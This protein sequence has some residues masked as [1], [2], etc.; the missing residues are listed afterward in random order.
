MVKNMTPDIP[1]YGAIEAGGTKFICATGSDPDHI[2]TEVRFSTTTPDETI[3]R[4][5]AFFC[6]QSTATPLTAIGVA[7]FGP[8]DLD[9][10][11]PAYGYITSTPKP[12][13]AQTNLLG[14]IRD[15]LNLPAGF[16]TDTNAA[17]L[18]EY[19]W[20]AGQGLDDFIYLT[21]GTGIGG[22]IIANGK[23]V[24]GLVH[25][26]M[27]HILLSH[28]FKRD[29]FEGFCP[30]H[31]DCFEGLATGPAL[32]ARWKCDPETLPADHPAWELEAHYIA[33]ALS[34][35]VCTLSPKRIILGG[36]VMH[37]T[38]LFPM[39]RAELQKLLNGYVRSNVIAKHMD[40]YVVAPGLGNHAGI[41]GALALAME[42]ARI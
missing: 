27:G 42:A 13:W 18:G 34:I 7:A 6:E 25:P 2:R 19:K 31:K 29:P 8:V 17:A 32:A 26:E 15:G 40:E 36:G 20:G 24:H 16:D 10:A 38:Q 22:G 12:G 21:I 39:I 9:P 28:D 11:S 4:C 23:L 3:D 30:Y 1:L 41:G 5:L 33:L 37:Q 14:R 35:Y